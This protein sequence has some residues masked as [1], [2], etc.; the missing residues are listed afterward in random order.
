M[1]AVVAT[2]QSFNLTTGSVSTPISFP[3]SFPTSPTSPISSSIDLTSRGSITLPSTPPTSSILSTLS[4]STAPTI[5]STFTITI[6]LSVPILLTA[7]VDASGSP[8]VLTFSLPVRVHP[9]APST[10]CQS[11]FSTAAFSF[12]SSCTVQASGTTVILFPLSDATVLPNDLIALSTLGNLV[13]A[14]DLTPA[15]GSAALFLSTV[16]SLAFSLSGPQQ[17]PACASASSAATYFVSLQS[18][19]FGRPMIAVWSSP[20][21]GVVSGVGAGSSYTINP[22][23]LSQGT[24]SISVTLSSVL[25]DS[26]TSSI[27]VAVT[28]DS[29][30]LLSLNPAAPFFDGRSSV[31]IS[32]SVSPSKCSPPDI[33]FA[34][35]WTSV[36]AS[37]TSGLVL[38]QNALVIPP[39]RLAA[40]R[41]TDSLSVACLVSWSSVQGS[42]Q[43]SQQLSAPVA[44]PQAPLLVEPLVDTSSSV[45]VGVPIELFV[46]VS[47]SDFPSLP[48]DVFTYQWSCVTSNGGQCPFEALSSGP[49]LS[50]A[51][52]KLPVGGIYRFILAVSAV[53][54]SKVPLSGG[55]EFFRSLASPEAPHVTSKIVYVDGISGYVLQ[56]SSTAPLDLTSIRLSLFSPNERDLTDL[57]ELSAA[58]ND[59]NIFCRKEPECLPSPGALAPNLRVSATDLSGDNAI[60]LMLPLRYVPIGPSLGSCTLTS[61]DPVPVSMISPLVVVCSDWSPNAFLS[62]IQVLNYAVTFT[63]ATALLSTGVPVGITIPK[64]TQP[65]IEFT[66]PAG[67][68]SV[69]VT[70]SNADGGST[71]F[72][73]SDSLTVIAYTPDQQNELLAALPSGSPEQSV[74]TVSSILLTSSSDSKLGD[75]LDHELLYH[76]LV[77]LLNGVPTTPSLIAQVIILYDQLCSGALLFNKL[78]VSQQI[79]LLELYN[80]LLHQIVNSGNEAASLLLD[81]VT[82]SLDQC[83]SL[84]GNDQTLLS[85]NDASK[86][87]VQTFMHTNSKT[88]LCGGPPFAQIGSVSAIKLTSTFGGQAGNLSLAFGP[89]EP[90]LFALGPEVLALLDTQPCIY[91]FLNAISMDLTGHFLPPQQLTV[92]N[93]SGSEIPLKGFSEGQI[94]IIFQVDNS[95]DKKDP[96]CKWLNEEASSP[97]ELDWSSDGCNLINFD[98]EH[99]VITC[100]CQHA[101]LFSALFGSSGDGWSWIQIASITAGGVAL[102]IVV[103]VIVGGEIFTKSR[104]SE[105]ARFQPRKRTKRSAP[106]SGSHSS[107]ATTQGASS[108]SS[109]R[110]E[111]I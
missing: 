43:G 23:A 85:F 76:T 84:S 64:Q 2:G 35:A 60:Q 62:S 97:G 34:Y 89:L 73:V 36:P 94:V 29:T 95:T 66:A 80:E 26:A 111:D 92:Y 42:F 33:S 106:P 13:S 46:R 82:A 49:S 39:D 55:I 47:S 101:T 81:Q 4:T 65:I 108:A 52:S 110:F 11:F 45:V 16:P 59:V 41:S 57:I 15:V 27:S 99:G 38:S 69:I 105:A 100:G 50:L 17:L 67:T 56:L 32:V 10:S 93:A 22:S 9:S 12:G 58:D 96:D 90:V 104:G 24:F 54:S 31:S 103:L 71:P 37:L 74:Q 70:I 86:T 75:S 40:F 14:S 28:G 83:L 25:G 18:G 102:L 30:P 88:N 3:T 51:T 91:V 109:G 44:I 63:S 8:I 68:F 48:S 72:V 77:A 19:S 79:R 7:F 61:Q 87:V 78:S 5:S 6:P 1:A 21:F 98:K 53:P 20:V 107:A